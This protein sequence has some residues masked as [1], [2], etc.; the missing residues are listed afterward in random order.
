VAR[1]RFRKPSGPGFARIAFAVAQDAWIFRAPF[2][3]A[4]CDFE[5]GTLGCD[6]ALAHRIKCAGRLPINSPRTVG[7]H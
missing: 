6:N 5:I 4:D 2:E 3:V 1:N 7:K